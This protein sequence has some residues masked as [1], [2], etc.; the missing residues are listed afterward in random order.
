MCLCAHLFAKASPF[1]EFK[2]G[3]LPVGGDPTKRSTEHADMESDQLQVP[4][5]LNTE[6]RAQHRLDIRVVATDMFPQL[7]L[8]GCQQKCVCVCVRVF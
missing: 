2:A 3:G 8:S 1:K 4:A 7:T 6:L 5:I